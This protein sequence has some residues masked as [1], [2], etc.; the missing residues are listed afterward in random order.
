MQEQLEE[1]IWGRIPSKYAEEIA[2]YPED[3]ENMVEK[4][5]D[6]RKRIGVPYLGTD[7][8]VI[9]LPGVGKS[10]S[11]RTIGITRYGRRVL[12]FDYDK[13]RK[14][15][16]ATTELGKVIIIESKSIRQYLNQLKEYGENPAEYETIWGYSIGVTEKKNP[17][18][19]YPEYDYPATEEYTNLGR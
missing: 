15:S 1:K 14:H 8:N 19:D 12:E 7:R 6:L 3:A 5:D 4:I 17:I 9:N 10:L 11:F 2:S 18:Y 13:V 16:P